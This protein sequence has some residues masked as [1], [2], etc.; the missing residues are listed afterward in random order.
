[1]VQRLTARTARFP[2]GVHAVAQRAVPWTGLLIVLLAALYLALPSARHDLDTLPELLRLEEGRLIDG[3]PAHGLYVP[4][5]WLM[6]SIGR[7]FADN[8]PAREAL[9]AA[10][11][12]L[13]A[14]GIGLFVAV[15]VQSGVSRGAAWAT[16]A[17]AALS[18]GYWTHVA[19]AFFVVPA[20]ATAMLAWWL[21][22][23]AGR[24][25]APSVAWHAAAGAAFGVSALLHQANLLLAPA[26]LLTSRP[27]RASPSA[28]LRAAAAAS[29][30]TLVI[31]VPFWLAQAA[32]ADVPT[33][34]LAGW[35]LGSHGGMAQGLWRR[36]GI[37]VPIATAIAW[38][39]TIVPVYEGMRLRSLVAGEL[40]PRHLPAQAALVVL[41]AAV[42]TALVVVARAA[43]R[44]PR[45][46]D[47][48][49]VAAALWF[50][51]SGAAVVWFDPAEVKLW[52]IPFFGLW[53]LLARALDA[54]AASSFGITRA[55][56]RLLPFAL[57]A[58]LGVGN[59]LIAVLPAHAEPPAS[60]LKARAAA[61]RIGNDDVVVSADFDWTG[62]LAYACPH[63][64]VLNLLWVEQGGRDASDA[65][66][67]A[68]AAAA[69]RGGVVY[70][71][72]ALGSAV[73]DGWTEG[74]PRFARLSPGEIDALGATEAWRFD[75]GEV[76]WRAA[77]LASAP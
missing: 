29:G 66:R 36:E 53:A 1:M 20:A 16:A 52:I 73:D 3:D 40:S 50:V 39:A 71:A 51:L 69:R 54:A 65:L 21:A 60:L 9:L 18:Y 38:L 4:M 68:R 63:C 76:V 57:A 75:D 28:V 30:A 37:D 7:G 27:D 34:H 5:G 15:L 14:A 11:A 58:A 19:D 56:V 13:G 47:R 42:L 12:V 48:R 24:S 8:L 32:V 64:R 72:G 59:L 35:F 25:T 74:M 10:N 70:L 26:L 33:E 22:L 67:D 41:G 45:R 77:P 61:H 23:R 55:L 2:G 17:A 49:L 44:G 43:R 31:A 6:W 46:L 62:H